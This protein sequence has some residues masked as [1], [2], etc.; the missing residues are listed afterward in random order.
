MQDYLP[1][2]LWEEVLFLL[3]P[4]GVARSV[5]FLIRITRTNGLS[6]RGPI[7]S[8]LPEWPLTDETLFFSELHWSVKPSPMR[9]GHFTDMQTCASCEVQILSRQ[10]IWRRESTLGPSAESFKRLPP[11]P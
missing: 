5:G 7:V 11:P 1:L 10:A 4:E 8:T 6:F 9:Y 3:P 2:E